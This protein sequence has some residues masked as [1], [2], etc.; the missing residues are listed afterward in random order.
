LITNKSPL[1]GHVNGNPKSVSHIRTD[2]SARI[3]YLHLLSKAVVV[4]A[5]IKL[6]LRKAELSKVICIGPKC[7]HPANI[8][9]EFFTHRIAKRWWAVAPRDCWIV[10]FH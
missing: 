1:P 8:R 5:K 6:Y 3:L 4:H 7:A 10:S 9:P 2:K